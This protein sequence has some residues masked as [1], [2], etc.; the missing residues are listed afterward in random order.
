V[1]L[2]YLTGERTPHNDPSATAQFAG[3]RVEHDA[4]ALA[5]AVLEGVA[6]ALSDCLDVLVA[7]GAAP[8]SCMFVGGGARSAFWARI[9]A[10]AT[11]LTLDIPAGAEVGAA[12]GAARLGML[13]SGLPESQVCTRP[14]IRQRVEPGLF[15]PALVAQRK[16]RTL[17]LYRPGAD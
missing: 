12:F 2:P 10:D 14:P 5:F 6:F 1:F 3:L 4:A 13:A 11:G 7:A 17:G 16:R 9:V 8:K 15:D